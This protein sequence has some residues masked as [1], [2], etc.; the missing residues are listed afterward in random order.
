ML[1]DMCWNF[2]QNRDL[3]I[4]EIQKVQSKYVRLREKMEVFTKEMET[5]SISKDSQLLEF[6]TKVEIQEK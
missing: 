4:E 2:I 3:E 6:K 1:V 5:S